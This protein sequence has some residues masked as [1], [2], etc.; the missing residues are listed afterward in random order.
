MIGEPKP[1][2]VG[3]EPPPLHRLPSG[4]DSTPQRD[5]GHNGKAK[6][7]AARRKT[8]DRF[9]VLNAFVDFTMQGLSRAETL[10]WLALFRDTK[11]DGLAPNRPNRLG[12]PGRG[13]RPHGQANRRQFA[14]PGFAGA[15]TSGKPSPRSLNVPSKPP[16]HPKGK[17]TWATPYMVTFRARNWGHGCHLSHKGP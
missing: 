8:A 4:N 13:E 2:P 5:Q 11:P 9:A 10:V 16:H 17:V 14:P 1:I 12:A 3:Q 7:K 15:G 6:G